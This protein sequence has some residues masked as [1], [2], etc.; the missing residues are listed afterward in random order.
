MQSDLQLALLQ[1]TR[2]DLVLLR[3]MQFD[4]VWQMGEAV[5]AL[6]RILP[7]KNNFVTKFFT[8]QLKNT[9]SVT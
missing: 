6:L 2:F 7:A 4:P 9:F 8:Q 1:W 3:W 5:S